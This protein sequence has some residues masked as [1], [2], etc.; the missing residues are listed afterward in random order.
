ML[1]F[2]PAITPRL[3][4]ITQFI[5]TEIL[6]DSIELTTD[7]EKFLTTDG[8]KINYSNQGLS[9]DEV[10]IK[11]HSLLFEEQILPQEINCFIFQGK[12]AFFP[13]KGDYSFDIFAASFYLISRYEEYLPSLPDEY[14]R[15]SHYNSLAY[16]QDFL[17][18]PLVNLWLQDFVTMLKA[19]FPEIR[20]R[21][22]TF[23]FLPTYDIDEPYSFKYKGVLRTIGGIMKSLVKGEWQQLGNRIRVLAKTKADP[24]FSF[25]WMDFVHEKFQLHPIYF[26]LVAKNISKYDRHIPPS[27]EKIKKLI[28]HHGNKYTVGLHPSWQT[29]DDPRLLTAELRTLEF[30]T[31]KKLSSSR[32]HFLRFTLPET[33]QRLLTSG[34]RQEFSMG[35]GTINGFRA[36]VASAFFWFDLTENAATELQVFPFCFMDANAFFEQGSTADQALEEMLFYYRSVF[37]VNGLLITLWHN[38]F[39]GTDPL[40]AGWR[41][42]YLKFLEIVSSEEAQ[43]RL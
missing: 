3:H 41:N 22:K 25:D 17:Q 16:Q 37:K 40:F 18:V 23:T 19:R 24:F 33:Y 13:T 38:T 31:R 28:L 10:W 1:L 26:F 9:Q 21:Q 5:A 27:G 43:V 8:A 32:Q 4:Y 36:S 15:F 14:G 20:L 6:A 29:G 34:I 12:K 2:S 39:L 35:Y 7:A 30:L 42:C 11:P